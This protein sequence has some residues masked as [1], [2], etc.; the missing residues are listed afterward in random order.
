MANYVPFLREH[1]ISLDYRPTLSPEEYR[2]VASETTAMRKIA[3]L[4]RSM[5]RLTERTPEH[6]LLLVH[7]LRLLN[8]FPGVDPPRRLDVYDLDDALFLGSPAE[9]NRRF[10]WAKQEARRSIECLRRARLVIAG[11]AFLAER[12]REYARHVEVIPTCVD[13]DLQPLHRHD[14]DGVVTVGWI[15]SHTTVEYLAPVLSVIAALNRQRLQAKLV[16]VGGDTGAREPWIEHVPWSLEH[17]PEILASF[18][19]G[20]MPLPD[21][22]WARGKCGYKILQYFSAGVPAIAS[23]VGL[24][25]ELIGA[26]HGLLADTAEEWVAALGALIRD[27]EQRRAQGTSA[28]AFAE[29]EYSYRRWAPELARLLHNIS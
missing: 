4:I 21:T 9:A 20:V 5:G 26:D 1:A 15:G 6:D 28:R 11:N 25:R 29:R 23:P 14:H 12:S 22:D 13:P 19:I 7:R 3:V 17:E 24:A 16:V 27:D 10:Q 8:P 18:D 2:L